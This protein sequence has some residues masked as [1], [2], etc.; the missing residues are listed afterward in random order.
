MI[1]IFHKYIECYVKSDTLKSLDK[2]YKFEEVTAKFL[3]SFEKSCLK[4]FLE[5]LFFYFFRN[6]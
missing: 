6:A 4:V 2:K 5:I 1:L 3:V